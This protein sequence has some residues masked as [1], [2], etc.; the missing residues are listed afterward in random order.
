M[1]LVEVSA[2]LE[3]GWFHILVGIEGRMGEDQDCVGM[4]EREMFQLSPLRIPHGTPCCGCS[5]P[6]GKDPV[7]HGLTI[8]HI[9]CFWTGLQIARAHGL[10]VIIESRA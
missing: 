3:K 4:G 10:R 5:F 7:V 1:G 8:Y 9:D 2:Y 6:I